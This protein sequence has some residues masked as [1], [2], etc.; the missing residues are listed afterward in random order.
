MSLR[1]ND[2]PKLFWIIV[3]IA[4]L[5]N[6]MGVGAFIYDA[7][8]SK[9]AIA[10][11]SPGQQELYANNPWYNTLAYGIAT[12]G[13]LLGSIGLVLRKKWSTPVLLASLIGVI[14]WAIHNLGM[15]NVLEVMGNSAAILP[16]LIAIISLYLWYFSKKSAKQGILT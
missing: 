5:W 9:E 3:G 11:L 15:T 2:I 6:I 7:T 13:G 16:I 1:K 10:E 4:V 8:L 14:V 12:I